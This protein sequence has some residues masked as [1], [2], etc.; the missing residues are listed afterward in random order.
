VAAWK[1]ESGA[2][3]HKISYMD[4]IQYIYTKSWIFT[5]SFSV[6][7]YTIIY[8]YIMNDADHVMDFVFF[9]SSDSFRI[10]TRIYRCGVVAHKSF[11]NLNYR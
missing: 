1:Y 10:V 11:I 3:A 9:F 2:V 6:Y 7:M 5:Y 8:K 4:F